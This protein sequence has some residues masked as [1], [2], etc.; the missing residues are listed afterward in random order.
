[1]LRFVSGLFVVHATLARLE[2]GANS[3]RE[4]QTPRSSSCGHILSMLRRAISPELEQ[5][6]GTGGAIAFTS[7]ALSRRPTGFLDA[8]GQSCMRQREP[9]RFDEGVEIATWAV[10]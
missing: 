3:R 1:M 2:S 8:C 4:Y 6:V 5:L 10:G 7:E 9:C